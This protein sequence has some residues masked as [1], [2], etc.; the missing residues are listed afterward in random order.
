[1]LSQDSEDKMWSRFVIWPQ[2]VTLA[3]WTRSSGL[4][5]LWQCF[6]YIS[7]TFNAVAP[8]RDIVNVFSSS[9]N[10]QTKI[11]E[12]IPAQSWRKQ[13]ASKGRPRER[14]TKR[15][16]RESRNSKQLCSALCQAVKVSHSLNFS[17]LTSLYYFMMLLKVITSAPREWWKTR[18]QQWRWPAPINSAKAQV[19]FTASA[20]KSCRSTC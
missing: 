20:S 18:R 6:Q 14:K 9:A 16:P 13:R 12:H 17:N 15:G 4:L 7:S 8:L 2:E 3:R 10:T 1:M 11:T 19:S 5:C